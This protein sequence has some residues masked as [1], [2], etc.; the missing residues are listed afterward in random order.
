MA[1]DFRYY[2]G[3]YEVRDVL[4]TADAIVAGDALENDSGSM[5][6]AATSERILGVSMEGNASAA[7]MMSTLLVVPTNTKF[8][9]PREAGTLGV[10]DLFDYWDLN[11]ADGL[12]YDT[13]TND[14]FFLLERL[15]AD[16]GVGFF[17]IPA[18]AKT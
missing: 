17:A 6:P 5:S 15:S 12:A 11:S 4:S 9:G 16:L 8:I 14:D 3:P 1:A 10:G 13:S 2:S 7:I 18:Y